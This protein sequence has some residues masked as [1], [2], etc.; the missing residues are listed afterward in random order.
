MNLVG[1]MPIRNEAWVCGLS[2]RAALKYCDALVILNHASTDNTLDIIG[3]VADEHPGRIMLLHEPDGTW[4]EMA[5]RQRMLEAARKLG[6]SHVCIID[7]DEVLTGNLA[8]VIRAYIEQ[9]QPTQMLRT[10][11]YNM[12]GSH[13]R[14]GAD[15]SY[16]SLAETMLAFADHPSLHWR[17]ENGYDH[18]HR[19]PYG[20]SKGAKLPRDCGGVMHLQFVYLR[21]LIAK[22]ALY[23]VTE[24]IRWPHKSRAEIDRMYSDAPKWA[25]RTVTAQAPETWWEPYQRL[26]PYLDLKH[27]P[28]QEQACRQMIEK[29]G[30]DRF[31]GLD[32]FGLV[33]TVNA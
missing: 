8:G 14:Y 16:W 23:K 26:L 32:L 13:D 7:S 11:M 17:A 24:T 12:V 25:R 10:A 22:H 18:H 4:A 19:E 30:A 15:E 27:E 20:A 1:L 5:H 29:Y 3:E 9:L 33:G 31:S 6:A 21:R 28:W 2:I